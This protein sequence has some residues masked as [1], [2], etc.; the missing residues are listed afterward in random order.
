MQ[1]VSNA[2]RVQ[3]YELLPRDFS[4]LGGELGPTMKLRRSVVARQYAALIEGLYAN[5][6]NS[7]ND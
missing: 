4:I 7:T 3:R 6:E 5:A 2:A 1:A